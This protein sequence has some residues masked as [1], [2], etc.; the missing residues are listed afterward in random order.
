M[1]SNFSS[2]KVS[3]SNWSNSAS[4]QV[5]NSDAGCFRDDEMN[6]LILTLTAIYVRI[7]ISIAIIAFVLGFSNT[8]IA[9]R[10]SQMNNRGIPHH[11]IAP[12]NARYTHNV[13]A[14]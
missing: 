10:I 2:S 11:T 9:H 1:Y 3:S 5:A 12:M 14:V 13:T 8:P 6:V 4:I 7:G